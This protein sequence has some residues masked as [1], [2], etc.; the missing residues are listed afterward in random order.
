MSVS[1]SAWEVVLF[2][3]KFLL[4]RNT[5][6][7]VDLDKTRVKS[8]L[9]FTRHHLITHTNMLD[10]GSSAV[11]VKGDHMQISFK[12]VACEQALLC[13]FH[14]IPQMENLLG[15]ARSLINW[16]QIFEKLKKNA[17]NFSG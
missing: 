14:D 3:L 6:W 13:T 15:N 17:K 8:F 11:L 2:N 4:R 1:V 12:L 10:Y 9:N 5:Q 7:E 16:R